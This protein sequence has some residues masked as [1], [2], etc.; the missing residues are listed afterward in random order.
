MAAQAY[1]ALGEHGREVEHLREAR[2]VEPTS[3]ELAVEYA[4]A[5]DAAGQHHGLDREINDMFLLPTLGS[6]G[7]AELLHV[8]GVT[9][10]TL[11]DTAGAEK[12]WREAASLGDVEAC[13]RYAERL[14]ADG[15]RQVEAIAAL[16]SLLVLDPGRLDGIRLLAEMYRDI[17]AIPEATVCGGLLHLVDPSWP[18]AEPPPADAV[19][20]PPQ[21]L[22]QDLCPTGLRPAALATSLLWEHG[23]TLLRT[24][25]NAFGVSPSQ[26]LSP[27]EDVPVAAVYGAAI[28][29]LGVPKTAM[30]LRPF[31]DSLQVAA[32]VPP[33][34]ICGADI[35]IGVPEM[36]FRVARAVAS[37]RPEYLLWTAL[38]IDKAKGAYEALRF[39]FGPAEGEALTAVESA[40]S[41]AQEYVRTLPPKVQR[42]LREILAPS[43]LPPFQEAYR[44]VELAL[45]RAALVATGD[46]AAALRVV[47]AEREELAGVD[48]TRPQGFSVAV[49]ASELARDI[50]RFALSDAYLTLRFRLEES[51]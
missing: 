25:L 48:V 28:R 38:P 24:D 39:A 47:A 36:R 34:V 23:A 33:S 37:T 12:A 42:Q 4:R 43:P 29:L 8:L 50:V 9:R 30:F 31:G 5:R 21:D 49:R 15:A 13:A 11:G 44:M 22:L 32:T 7:R 40:M 3:A 19:R 1:R 46:P 18:S 14:A 10:M 17:G 35:A 26:R 27:L 51:R 16:K 2:K 20:A 41:M 45:H 6:S